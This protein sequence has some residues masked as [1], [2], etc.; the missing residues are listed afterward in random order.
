ME[1]PERKRRAQASNEVKI[2][3]GLIAFLSFVIPFV[4]YELGTA[5]WIENVVQDRYAIAV[6]QTVPFG[7]MFVCLVLVP[8]IDLADRWRVAPLKWISTFISLASVLFIHYLIIYSGPKFTLHLALRV[9][10]YLAVAVLTPLAIFSAFVE[11]PFIRAY[12]ILDSVGGPKFV[13]R[14]THALV[15]YPLAIWYPGILVGVTLASTRWVALLVSP[16][17]ILT[18]LAYCWLQDR[19][20]YPTEAPDDHLK[21]VATTPMLVPNKDSWRR[22][23]DTLP[24]VIREV[25]ATLR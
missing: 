9:V 21:Y 1:E 15:R 10:G 5:T 22:A 6:M 18:Y 4:L 13:N 11:I 8:S 19:Y 2:A 23:W 16:V 14:G 20:V 17:L 12:L 7:A 24:E 3:L 25:T